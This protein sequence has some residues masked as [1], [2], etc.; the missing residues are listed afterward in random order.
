MKKV[1][2]FLRNPLKTYQVELSSSASDGLSPL[3]ITRS[4]SSFNLKKKTGASQPSLEEANTINYSYE[5]TTEVQVDAN[6]V[7]GTAS[8]EKNIIHE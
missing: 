5:P 3:A 7:A 4:L 8:K 6:L 2:F 1:N